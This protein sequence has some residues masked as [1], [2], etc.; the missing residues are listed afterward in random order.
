PGLEQEGATVGNRG[1][2]LKQ[3]TGLA[4]ENQRRHRGKP[5]A[6]RFGGGHVRPW[7]LMQGR[8]PAP[9][10]G[11]PGVLGERHGRSVY[12]PARFSDPRTGAFWG[13]EPPARTPGGNY[14]GP[15][16]HYV[17]DQDLGEAFYCI[18]DLH[19]I[20]V[21][22]EP[23]ELSENTLDTAA[24]LLAAGLDPSRCT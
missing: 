7:R 16:R 13:A 23:S 1:Q 18:V 20:S 6:H 24:T 4:G 17:T 9:G 22:Y 3:L 14:S 8:K 15:I 21:P 12:R 11:R 5:V 19:S 2:R 10:G